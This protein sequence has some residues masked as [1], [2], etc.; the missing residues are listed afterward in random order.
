[1]ES[2]FPCASGALQPYLFLAQGVEGTQD[3]EFKSQSRRRCMSCGARCLHKDHIGCHLLLANAC[4]SLNAAQAVTLHT[5]LG[6][7]KLELHCDLVSPLMHSAAVG[8]HDRLK[9]WVCTQVAHPFHLS[10][11]VPRACENFLALAASGYYDGTIFHR[12]IKGFMVQGGASCQPSI[13]A[14]W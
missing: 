8:Y 4:D 10:I 9:T 1:M 7:M 2:A 13:G 14:A 12:N 6:D 3:G 11:Q 5:N